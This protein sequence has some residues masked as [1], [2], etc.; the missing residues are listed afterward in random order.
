MEMPVELPLYRRVRE[1]RR[2]HKG[3]VG[4]NPSRPIE[5]LDAHP[6]R[7]RRITDAEIEMIAELR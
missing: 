5:E 6:V 4:A 7:E 2:H 1:S 3:N